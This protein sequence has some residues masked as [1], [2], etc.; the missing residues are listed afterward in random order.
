[1]AD[2]FQ[3]ITFPAN[4]AQSYVDDRGVSRGIFGKIYVP[5][6]VDAATMTLIVGSSGGRLRLP[7]DRVVCPE[8][9]FAPR[10]LIFYS[11]TGGSVSVPIGPRA[12]L[13]AAGSSIRTNLIAAGFQVVC[14][15]LVGEKFA[16]IVD[17]LR[18]AGFLG[19]QAATASSRP[20]TGG[21]QPNFYGKADYNSDAVFGTNYVLPYKVQ[22]DVAQVFP[23][24][25]GT[26]I[27]SALGIVPLVAV[28]ACPGSDPRTSRRYIVQSLVTE[29]AIVRSQVA[30]LPM[31]N[32][33][34]SE[35][36]AAGVAIA[37]LRHVQCIGYKGETND[38][39]HKLLP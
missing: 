34:A 18:P 1:M 30:E 4:A 24:I 21:I 8:K 26:V 19:T 38:R 5:P 11:N 16:N 6:G 31:F 39:F 14:V 27:Q 2:N 22:S 17:D 28:N 25:Y 13:I 7:V 37:T 29:N 32:H 15:K 33:L 3:L 20:A 36:A 12:S 9:G 35:I 10:K 23:S